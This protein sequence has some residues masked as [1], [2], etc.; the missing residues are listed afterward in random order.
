MQAVPRTQ[1]MPFPPQCPGHPCEKAPNDI[2]ATS[3]F[4]VLR[5]LPFRV[6]L[7]MTT[8]K[9]RY[10]YFP[11][12]TPLTIEAAREDRAATSRALLPGPVP[13]SERGNSLNL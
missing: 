6:P 7:R 3:T 9:V 5:L 11:L 10:G 8:G 2:D 13:V 1:S 12:D 4:G